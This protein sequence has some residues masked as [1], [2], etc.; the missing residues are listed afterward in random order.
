MSDL[1]DHLSD[2]LAEEALVGS[3]LV[4]PASLAD[5]AVMGIRANFF[6]TRRLGTIW[7]A[8]LDLIADNSSSDIVTVGDVLSKRKELSDIGGPAYLTQLSPA[9]PNTVHAPTTLRSSTACG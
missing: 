1:R 9:A 4:N 5:P 6:F 3:A 8:I 2:R 7:Q